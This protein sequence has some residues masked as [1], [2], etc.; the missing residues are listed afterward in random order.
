MKMWGAKSTFQNQMLFFWKK[1][2]CQGGKCEQITMRRIP[3][4]FI[5][6]HAVNIEQQENYKHSG[7]NFQWHNEKYDA[8]FV[9]LFQSHLKSD[10]CLANG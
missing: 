7:V 9:T 10:E 5:S 8:F 2:L 6:M 1:T 3:V 4:G